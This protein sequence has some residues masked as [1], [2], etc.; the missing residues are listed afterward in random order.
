MSDDDISSL[1]RTIPEEIAK[2]IVSVQPIDVS[3]DWNALNQ[4]PLVKSLDRRYFSRKSE[5]D[6]Q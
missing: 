6:A 3:I 4:H 5:S 1:R 2:Q